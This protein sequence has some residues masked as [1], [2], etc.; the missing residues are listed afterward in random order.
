MKNFARRAT[1]LLITAGSLMAST[2]TVTFNYNFSGLAICSA[3][4]TTNCV[5]HFQVGTVSAGTFTP[6]ASVPVPLA[7]AAGGTLVVRGAFSDPLN[8]GATIVVA[9]QAVAKDAQGNALSTDPTLAEATTN[10]APPPL[11][12]GVTGQVQ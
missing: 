9:A 4:V 7:A 2:V 10:P 5:D 11:P 1:L 12:L 6:L 8:I 3:S